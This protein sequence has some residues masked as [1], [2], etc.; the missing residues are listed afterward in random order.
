MERS[1]EVFYMGEFSVIE[2]TDK[3][4]K[5][6][7]ENKN[8]FLNSNLQELFSDVNET[9]I[10]HG[11]E[12]SQYGFTGVRTGESCLTGGF[13]YRRNG[14]VISGNL[15]SCLNAEVDETTR[16]RF[17]D[18]FLKL[19]SNTAS[20]DYEEVR[21]LVS[22][23]DIFLGDEVMEAI[24]QEYSNDKV[25]KILSEERK[26]IVERF[27]VVQ[28]PAFTEEVVFAN[29]Q[30]IDAS[31]MNSSPSPDNTVPKSFPSY[32]VRFDYKDKGYVYS[33]SDFGDKSPDLMMTLYK[34]EDYNKNK[35]FSKP[36]WKCWA[37]SQATGEEG[38]LPA[39][40]ENVIPSVALE[41][42]TV[43]DII[44]EE[45]ISSFNK[46]SFIPLIREYNLALSDVQY[47]RASAYMESIADNPSHSI[48][49][50]KESAD[51][52]AYPVKTWDKNGMELIYVDSNDS[53]LRDEN[54]QQL[55]S[56]IN[57]EDFNN[58]YK[59]V[60]M[61]RAK[62]IGFEET[63]LQAKK[64]MYIYEPHNPRSKLTRIKVNAGD[65]INITSPSRL[66]VVSA[67]KFRKTY[68]VERERSN[69]KKET[70]RTRVFDLSGQKGKNAGR[71]S[72]KTGAREKKVE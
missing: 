55:I 67:D 2:T 16:C 68:T 20:R 6:I 24:V 30:V 19:S 59:I 34:E 22:D 57:R 28:S 41:G 10:S 65:Y 69:P 33:C 42:R 66:S 31:Q 58:R 25:G 46:E 51:V 4:D 3:R 23:H 63:F 14:Q 72:T 54:G 15:V 45:R 13:E 38:T 52:K 11:W 26:Q 37:N 70:K 44:T 47:E 27:P 36:V 39:G 48:I 60:G 17:N 35:V 1:N 53:P 43:V 12:C 18:V 29:I 61:N 7:L 40:I 50:A 56:F 71:E 64:D 8:Y 9:L 62:S 49:K 5:D 32:A 21:G